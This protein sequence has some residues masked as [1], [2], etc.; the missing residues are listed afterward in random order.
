MWLSGAPGAGKGVLQSYVSELRGITAEPI[1]V[2]SLLRGPMVERLKAQGKLVDDRQVIQKLLERLL[3]PEYRR[4]VI[5]DGYPRTPVQGRCIKLLYDKML[6]L[7]HRYEGKAVQH[8]FR[9]PI[10]QIT[11][12]FIEEQV[13][14][15]RQLKRGREVAA[16]NKRV[17]DTGV[18]V[19]VPE[20]STDLDEELARQR[21]AL[22]KTQIYGSLQTIKKHFQFHFIDAGGTI[23]QV[24]QRIRQE[25]EYQS[26]L[27]LAEETFEQIRKISLAVEVIR[28]A[29]HELIRRLDSYQSN[30]PNLFRSV[31]ELLQDEFVSIIRRQAL[32]GCAIIRT[33][34]PLLDTPMAVDMALDI[35]T[36]RGYQVVLDVMKRQHPVKVDRET[37]Q[38]ISRNYKVYEFTVSFERPAIRRVS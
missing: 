26:S 28:D 1:E 24:K 22:F 25:L 34:N 29:R 5:V 14:V 18:G 12:L 7:R 21:Y 15:E 37:F 10:F 3:R 23:D 11:V 20:R 32:S 2:S 33:E 16:M 38:I 8:R 35:L 36:E 27:E 9:R 31:I 6:E 13:S 17:R 19:I 4:G 30:H